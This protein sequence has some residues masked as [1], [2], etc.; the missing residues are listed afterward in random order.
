MYAARSSDVAHRATSYPVWEVR[1]RDV[2][3]TI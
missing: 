3:I 2:E 1:M